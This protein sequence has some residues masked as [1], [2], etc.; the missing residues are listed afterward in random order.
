MKQT[1]TRFS[2]GTKI[3]EPRRNKNQ[4]DRGIQKREL[5]SWKTQLG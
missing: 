3:Q 1:Q 5:R 2:K 4:G